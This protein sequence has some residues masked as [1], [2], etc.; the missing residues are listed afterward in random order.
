MT[1]EL[2]GQ[3]VAA[4]FKREGISRARWNASSRVKGWGNWTPG[5]SV[6]PVQKFNSNAGGGIR[7]KNGWKRDWQG[8]MI[9]RGAWQNTG[10]WTVKWNGGSYGRSPQEDSRGQVAK[11]LKAFEAAGFT[12]EAGEYDGEWKVYAKKEE[13]SA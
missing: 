8:N 6:E 11:A 4:I 1:K 5:V 10:T 9:R 13:E 2:T 12:V 3:K 7:S